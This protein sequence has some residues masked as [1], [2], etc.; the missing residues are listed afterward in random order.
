VP[1]PAKPVRPIR[2]PRQL[3]RRT[4]V[5][6]ELRKRTWSHLYTPARLIIVF[7]EVTGANTTWHYRAT[8]TDGTVVVGGP[9][10]RKDSAARGLERWAARGY[11]R[12]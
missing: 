7:S 12:P 10:T 3:P 1:R 6:A 2:I 4:P 8:F 5:P 9:Y 11:P